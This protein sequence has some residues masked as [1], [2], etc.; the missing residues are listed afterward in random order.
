MNVE[1]GFSY[2]LLNDSYAAGCGALCVGGIVMIPFAL[3]YGRRPIYVFSLAV[4]CGMAI[5]SAKQHS[6]GDLMGTNVIMCFAGALCEIMVQ[7]TVADMYF[8]HQRGVMNNIYIWCLTIGASLAPTIGGYIAVSIGWRWVWWL[9]AIFLGFSLFAFFFLYEETQFDRPMEGLSPGGDEPEVA[10]IKKEDIDEAKTSLEGGPTVGITTVEIDTS[11]APKPYRQKLNL[12]KATEEPLSHY[13]SHSLRPFQILYHIPAVLYMSII[14]GAVVSAQI[15][16]ITVYSTY[17]YYP[18][19]NFTALQVG[20]MNLP[21][22]IGTLLCAFICGP[23]SDWMILRM[24]KRNNGIYEPEMRLWLILAFLP[25]LVVGLLMFGIG[26]A[27]SRPW[28][29]LCIGQV[30]AAFGGVP[31]SSISLTYLTDAYTEVSSPPSPTAFCI[32]DRMNTNTHPSQIIS[33]S[34]VAVIFVKN[35]FPTILVFSLTPWIAATGMANVFIVLTVLVVFVLLWN[36]LFLIYGK[37]FRERS[38][39]KYRWLA[40]KVV[41]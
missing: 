10:A 16:P 33:E 35:L 21:G 9:L 27:D 34:M 7:M 32:F 29:F 8:V 18:P 3:K 31:A 14:Q 6:V 30:L 20:L 39:E 25:L 11:I 15:V 40:G 36:I 28:W 38:A 24:A 23:L 37:R 17:M 22:F 12:F 1:L 13:I 5:W 26:L 41:Q 19:Y 4:Q 2:G